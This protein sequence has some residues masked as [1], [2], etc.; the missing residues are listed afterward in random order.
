MDYASYSE[1]PRQFHYWTGVSTIA[2]ALRRKVW[3][4]MK[5]FKWHCNFFII[6]VAPAGI[7]AKSTTA[8]IGMGILAELP[9]INM[10]PA[11]TSWQALVKKMSEIRED[12][13]EADGG[14]TPM[15]AI[16]IV[17]SE[18]GTF[19]DPRNREMVDALTSLW[20]GREGPWTKLTKQDGEE[21][22]INPW[23][24]IIGCT[25]P[26]WMANNL[27]EYFAGGG[28]ASRTVFVYAEEKHKY[29][30]YPFMH[31]P[32][33][34]E[35]VASQLVEDLEQ[36]SSLTGPFNLTKDAIQWGTEWYKEHY[37][38]DHTHLQS[39]QFGGYLARKQ[40]HIHKLAMVIAAS[41][42]DELVITRDDLKE[43]FER[44]TSL[45]YDLPKI[46]GITYREDTAKLTSEM[47]QVVRHEGKISK[48]AL[49][50]KYMNTISYDTYEGIV[51]SMVNSDYVEVV[52]I[53]G[54][55]MLKTKE[56]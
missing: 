25:T 23:I 49:F 18:L 46:Y 19:F 9:F 56:S 17:A 36:I 20:D 27:T 6:F 16:T 22:V 11:A 53:A 47:I 51:K 32:D 12:F 15:C 7:V 35:E 10:G 43:A 26:S 29:V 38:S 40:T 1:A 13:Q 39:E 3:I 8:D 44:V 41:Q 2:G 42:R 55:I 34:L 28:F 54:T 5:Y 48:T 31:T 33:N 30:A 24:N 37:S 52:N 4:D 45:E 14:F 21:I 50:R